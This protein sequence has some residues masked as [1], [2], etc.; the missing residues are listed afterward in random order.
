MT[1]PPIC[2]GLRIRCVPSPDFEAEIVL[3]EVP[4]RAFKIF[5]TERVFIAL[6]PHVT[7]TSCQCLHQKLASR[8]AIVVKSLALSHNLDEGREFVL[9]EY[10]LAIFAGDIQ[11]SS[12]DP[13]NILPRLSMSASLC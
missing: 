3:D 4:K 9:Q 10:L 11:N 1:V 5:E 7:D 12:F 8:F 2:V 6:K 13:T